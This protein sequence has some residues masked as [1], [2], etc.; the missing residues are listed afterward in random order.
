MG[1]D[2][3]QNV[4]CCKFYWAQCCRKKLLNGREKQWFHTSLIITFLPETN[5][6]LLF[7]FQEPKSDRDE[8]AYS[9]LGA[10]WRGESGEH[11]VKVWSS[12]NTSV[13]CCKNGCPM[14]RH[15]TSGHVSCFFWKHIMSTQFLAPWTL[16]D[17]IIII[18]IMLFVLI[19]ALYRS[20]V[21]SSPPLLEILVRCI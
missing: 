15:M 5:Y 21:C 18:I 14:E 12:L 3:E 17:I 8:M 11:Y 20:A 1:Q 19:C 6:C 2:S 13:L 7:K 16:E 4:C 10:Q 9:L